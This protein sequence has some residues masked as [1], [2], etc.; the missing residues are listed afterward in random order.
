[1]PLSRSQQNY[2]DYHKCVNAKGEEFAPCQQFKKAYRSLCPSELA[3]NTGG[4]FGR[5]ESSEAIVAS[6]R[7]EDDG[8]DEAE[9][10]MGFRLV[11]SERMLIAFRFSLPAFA[12]EWVS[13]PTVDPPE[14][15][16][17]PLLRLPNGT[18]R[19]RPAL[20]PPP[21]SHRHLVARV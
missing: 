16:A 7:S 13:S 14:Q 2:V 1:M 8:G 21:S 18:N 17:D 15:Y 5:C 9:L 6:R 11:G 19:S 3:Y 20:S 4:S 12:D 10:G